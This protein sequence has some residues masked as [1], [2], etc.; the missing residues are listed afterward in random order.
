MEDH[1]GLHSNDKLDR[2]YYAKGGRLPTSPIKEEPKKSSF[3][4][5]Q[6]YIDKLEKGKK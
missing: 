5:L 4:G 1:S 6:L 3:D 2:Q